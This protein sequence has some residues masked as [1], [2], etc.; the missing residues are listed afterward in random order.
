MQRKKDDRLLLSMVTLFWF[1]QYVF[2]P[3]F[4]PHL[5]ALGIS[6]SLAGVIMGAYGVSQLILRIPVSVGEDISGRHKAFVVSGLLVMMTASVIPLLFASS[7]AYLL[8]RTLAGVAASTWVSYTAAFTQGAQDVK[9]RMGRLIAANNLGVLLSYL[10]G[11]VMFE[12][13][14]INGLFVLSA[15]SALCALI[16]ALR[17][18]PE[19][20]CADRKFDREAFVQV[21][22]NRHLIVCSLMMALGQTVVYAT[23]STFVSNYAKTMGADSAML[24]VIAAA[25]TALGVA[26]S[27][28]YARGALQKLTERAQ[29]LLAFCILALYCGLL[30]LCAAP[31]Q[32][33]LAQMVGGVGRSILYTLLMAIAPREVPAHAKTTANGVFQSVYSLGLSAGPVIMGSLLD[34]SGSYA[35]SFLM[36]GTAALGGAGWTLLA[37]GRRKKD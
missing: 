35:F 18:R 26:T 2:V 15:V 11:A 22:T 21:I 28:A 30:P 12:R 29:M 23:S 34:F 37:F 7:L 19:R 16:L 5:T 31:W 6:A 36:M 27:W 9:Q 10:T 4:S 1:A 20:I 17:W 33:A 8:S 32:I 14:G 24:S 3:F 13:V 25:F